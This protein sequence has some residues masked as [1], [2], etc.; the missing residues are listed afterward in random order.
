MDYRIVVLWPYRLKSSLTLFRNP[1][2]IFWGLLASLLLAINWE[3]LYAV[4]SEKA[5]EASLGYFML[6]SDHLGWHAGIR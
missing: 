5:T 1:K 3:L 2:V 6:P 4:T